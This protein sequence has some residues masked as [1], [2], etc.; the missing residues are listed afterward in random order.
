[1]PTVCITVADLC[2]W[3]LEGGCLA[4]LGTLNIVSSVRVGG[5]TWHLVWDEVDDWLESRRVT[6]SMV[7]PGRSEIPLEDVILFSGVNEYWFL[8][9]L[10]E[11]CGCGSCLLYTSPS[12]RD[13]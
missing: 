6:F 7:S 1:M 3:A 12:P 9:G 2:N 10:A 5:A 11:Y 13:S 8:N 4:S